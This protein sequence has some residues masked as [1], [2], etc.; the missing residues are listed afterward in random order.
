MYAVLAVRLGI[1][2]YSKFLANF[3]KCSPVAGFRG[4]LI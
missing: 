3:L 4:F 2:L 1:F